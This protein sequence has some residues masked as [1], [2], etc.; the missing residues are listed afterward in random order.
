MKKLHLLFIAVLF[1]FSFLSAQTEQS[2]QLKDGWKFKVGDNLDYAKP[3]YDDSQWKGIQ[4]D[5]IWEQQGYDP[6]DG[7]AWYRIKVFIPSSLKNNSFLKDS[8]KIFLG[9]INNFDQSFINGN[10]FG[11]NGKNVTA[12]TIIDTSFLYAPTILWDYNRRYTLS[13]DDPRILW[14]KENVIAVRVFDQGGQGGIYTG[15]AAISMVHIGEYLSLDYGQVPFLFKNKTA[16]KSFTIKNTS[17]KLTINGK[18]TIKAENKLNKKIIY[19]KTE[20]LKLEPKSS[21]YFSFSLVNQ[22]QSSYVNYI[23]EF[24]HNKEQTILK[25]ETPYILTSAPSQKPKIN[26]AKVYGQRPNKPFLYTIAAT[27]VKPMMFDAVNLP[28]GLSIDEK[29]GIITG[30]VSDKAEY[31]VTLVAKNKFGS[32]KS[33]LRIEIGDK[34][35]LTPPMGWN[36]WNVWGL[37]VDQEKV[38]AS[39][40]VYKEKGLMNHGWTFINIDDGWEIVG[41][42]TDPKRD[43]DG[44]ILCNSKFPNM[45]ALGDSLHALG[46]KF[47]IYSS[48]GPLTCGGYTATYQHELQDAKSF[49]SWGI[50]YLKYDWCSY[51]NIAKDTSRAER[52]KPYTIMQDALQKIDR[53]IVYSLCQYGMSKVWEWGG[54]VGGNL[55]RTTGD[56]NDTWQSLSDIGFSQI[57]NAKYAKPGNW[58]DPDM[59]V[60]G[61][62]GWG[63]SLHPTKLTPDEQYIHISMWSLLSAPLLIGCDLTRLDDFTLNLLT[64][65][66]VLA[67]DQDPLGK[68]ATPKIIKDNIQ[69]WVKDLEDGNKAIGIFNLGSETKKYSLDF[70]EIGIKANSKVR[71]LWRQKNLGKFKEK[72]ETLVPSHGVVLIKL[73]E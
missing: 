67:I 42:S 26:G 29:T 69:V 72:F 44:N 59:L 22:D 55:W 31:N 1:S 16:S 51:D 65:D 61:W 70:S 27:G 71:D 58:N 53:D 11:I 6:L 40:K 19:E 32:A 63:P 15:N 25:E 20:V 18:F 60:V 54:S 12:N 5:K 4:V 9:K 48:P 34:L 7:Y 45:K 64:N 38:L 14:D 41:N 23:F 43:A 2:I 56:I 17:D 3:G 28:K 8:L 62:V 66:D 73:F 47:G 10:I 46:L 33:K 57:E 39:A 36:S 49:A 50:D 30:K 68:Q 24:A 13:V 37:T 52:I 35:A 21:K